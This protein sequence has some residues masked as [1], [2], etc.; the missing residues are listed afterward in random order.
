MVSYLD[1][2]ADPSAEVAAP[3]VAEVESVEVAAPAEAA[4]AAEFATPAE[5]PAIAESAP[6]P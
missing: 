1:R 4:E 2:T 3:V 5:A 6:A